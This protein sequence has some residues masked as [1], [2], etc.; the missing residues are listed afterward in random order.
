MKTPFGSY[1]LNRKWKKLKFILNAIRVCNIYLHRNNHFSYSLF[2]RVNNEYWHYCYVVYMHNYYLSFCYFIERN[3][4][5]TWNFHINFKKHW[6]YRCP[7]NNCKIALTAVSIILLSTRMNFHSTEIR[8]CPF[9]FFIRTFL[10]QKK[11]IRL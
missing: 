9:I 11:I 6:V 2:G 7:M 3:M 8:R 5:R 10:K 1:Q 4:I